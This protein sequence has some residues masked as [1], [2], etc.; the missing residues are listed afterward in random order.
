M[1]LQKLLKFFNF[2][3]VIP[4]AECGIPRKTTGFRVKP[5]M[6]LGYA[7]CRSGNPGKE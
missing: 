5:G 4:V 6:T 1:V 2:F 7:A 3:M